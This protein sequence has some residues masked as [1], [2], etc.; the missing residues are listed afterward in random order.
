MFHTPIE[1]IKFTQHEL[2]EK[3]VVH[4][5]HIAHYTQRPQSPEFRHRLSKHKLSNVY[6]FIEICHAHN[7]K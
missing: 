3:F 5:V 2:Q 4:I 1:A 6:I 7:Y